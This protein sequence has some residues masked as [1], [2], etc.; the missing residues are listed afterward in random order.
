MVYK[1]QMIISLSSV[2]TVQ[3]NCNKSVMAAAAVAP[4]E[5]NFL[6]HT[7][8]KSRFMPSFV[9]AF[10]TFIYSLFRNLASQKDKNSPGGPTLI[11]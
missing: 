4:N 5:C 2:G 6:S 1:Q 9:Y 3:K 7:A 10:L 11:Y 8:V